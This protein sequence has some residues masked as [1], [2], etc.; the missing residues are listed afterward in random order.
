MVEDV[1]PQE[2]GLSDAGSFDF[3]YD[4]LA[5]PLPATRHPLYLP[6]TNAGS[7]T[8]CPPRMTV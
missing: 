2:V 4:F 7:I 1:A 3:R 8:W 6:F 5:T